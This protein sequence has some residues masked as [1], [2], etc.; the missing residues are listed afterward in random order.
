MDSHSKLLTFETRVV[1]CA[2]LSLAL[3]PISLLLAFVSDRHEFWWLVKIS[4]GVAAV[5][6]VLLVV[7]N[8]VMYG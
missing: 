7:V 8:I 5:C 3:L 1:I 4:T 6:A 2:T